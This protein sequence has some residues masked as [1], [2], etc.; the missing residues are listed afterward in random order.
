MS[1]QK[2]KSFEQVIKTEY[3]I[4][5][6]FTAVFLFLPIVREIIVLLDV[7][8]FS[9][10]TALAQFGALLGLTQ[11]SLTNTQILYDLS[12]IVCIVFGALFPL[13]IAR[14]LNGQR[15]IHSLRDGIKDFR[16]ARTWQYIGLIYVPYFIVMALIMFGISNIPVTA[17]L[18]LVSNLMESG[19]LL[20]ICTLILIIVSA[21]ISTI[22]GIFI[23]S[24][25]TYIRSNVT[26]KQAFASIPTREFNKLLV[27][28]LIEASTGILS[29][30]AFITIAFRMDPVTL[31]AKLV[32]II[33][34]LIILAI[35][36]Q[37][38]FVYVRLSLYMNISSKVEVPVIRTSK[39]ESPFTQVS[40]EPTDNTITGSVNNQESG[41]S[42]SVDSTIAIKPK[43]AKRKHR[44][45]SIQ[46][47]GGKAKRSIK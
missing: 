31:L 4:I 33:S 39:M 34:G 1:K 47:V 43:Q 9:R 11:F 25:V 8:R 10:L 27:F 32:P 22:A 24:N 36:Y 3:K 18:T 29:L 16:N 45:S 46:A 23:I 41:N 17:V 5:L 28:N 13:V 26:I 30:L 2:K 15:L 35:I 14:K 7:V 21:L 12:L 44:I 40:N 37:L 38:L 42:Q 19:L 20:I 6:F